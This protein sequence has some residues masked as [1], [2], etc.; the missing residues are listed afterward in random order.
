MGTA[1]SPSGLA[2]PAPRPIA[3]GSTPITLAAYLAAVAGAVSAGMPQRSWV[4]ATVAAAKPGP[5]GHSLQ[6][7]DPAGGPS[8]PTMRAFLRT[9]DRD[10]IARRLGAPLDPAHL[11]GLT[12]VLEVE[13]EFHPRWGM[14]GRVVGLSAALR[15]SLM[16]RAL[17]EV[18]A[19]LKAERLY[20]R[21]RRLPTPADVLRIAVVHPAGAAGHADIAGDLARWERAGILA[22]T[23]IIAAFEGPRAAADLV[24]ALRRAVSGDDALPDVLVLVRGGGDRTGLLSLDT[25][26]VARAVCLCPVPIIAGLGH[27]IDSTLVDE[28]AAVSCHTPSKALAHLAGLIAGPARRARADMAAVMAGAERRVVDAAHRLDAARLGVVAGAERR[29]AAGAAHLGAARASFE[30]GVAGAGER[31]RSRDVEAARLLGDVLER[32]PLRLGEAGRQAERLAGVAMAGSRRRLEGADDGRS[33]LAAAL[34]RA[35]ARLDAAALDVARRREALPLDGARHLTDAG[36]DLGR[37]AALVES[38]GLDAT[39]QRGFALATRIDGT[40]VP[41]RAAALA[42]ARITL[43]F[44]DGAVAAHVGVPLTATPITGEAA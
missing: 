4:E 3:A 34:T 44:A 24:A 23:S 35:G 17:D 18:R 29:L 40:L 11:V 38:L 42:A 33:S 5:Y 32:A 15:E 1:M 22:V 12:A 21:Q 9:A 16:R 39:L 2:P 14:G 31:C 6:L 20:D 43:T 37:L 36:L 13:P 19:R 25:E 7:V 30:A 8:A 26:A 28:V 41:T 27:Q 10:A